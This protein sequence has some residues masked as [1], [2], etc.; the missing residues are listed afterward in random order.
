M[1]LETGGYKTIRSTCFGDLLHP[2][3]YRCLQGLTRRLNTSKLAT[4]CLS[5]PQVIIGRHSEIRLLEVVLGCHE[6]LDYCQTGSRRVSRW[7]SLCRARTLLVGYLVRLSFRDGFTTGIG[8]RAARH[9]ALGSCQQSC[10]G[11]LTFISQSLEGTAACSGKDLISVPTSADWLSRPPLA[12]AD[13]AHSIHRSTA[14]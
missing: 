13:P 1:V 3:V 6:H 9:E 4:C 7:S 12:R 14:P 8:V 2:P 11:L 10:R 5:F